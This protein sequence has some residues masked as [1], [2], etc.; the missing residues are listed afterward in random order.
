VS[1]AEVNQATAFYAGST[2]R[3]TT[4]RRKETIMKALQI[5][6]ASLTAGLA[7]ALL[8]GAFWAQNANIDWDRYFVNAD[9][10]SAV[11]AVGGALFVALTAGLVY[12][13]ARRS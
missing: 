12:R 2:V 7:A 8:S 10:V 3:R 1:A 5:T 4:N 13:A 6:T 9:L 11:G